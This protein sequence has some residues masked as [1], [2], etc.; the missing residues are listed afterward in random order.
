MHLW[1]GGTDYGAMDG[2]WGNHAFKV[3]RMGTT[4]GGNHL[5]V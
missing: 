4:F 1:Q 3:P 5:M 2:P